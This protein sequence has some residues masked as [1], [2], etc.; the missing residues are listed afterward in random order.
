[1]PGL[2]YHKIAG[3]VTKW[4]SA[5]PQ[6]KTKCWSKQTVDGLKEVTLDKEEVTISFDVTSSYTNVPVKEVVIEP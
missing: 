5:I 3:E 1:M 4:L 6:G 2:P